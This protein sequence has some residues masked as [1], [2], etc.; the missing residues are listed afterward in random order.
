[1]SQQATHI[2]ILDV[3][4]SPGGAIGC[5]VGTGIGLAWRVHWAFPSQDLALV[6]ALIIV[7]GC[8]IGFMLDYK[9]EPK[10]PKQPRRR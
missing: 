8:A 3:L 10:R 4:I 7:T 1:M 9:H 6:Q 2:G 5:I